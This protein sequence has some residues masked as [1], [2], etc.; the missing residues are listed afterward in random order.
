MPK[1]H[2]GEEHDR[3]GER[4][5][6]ADSKDLFSVEEG[7]GHLGWMMNRVYAASTKSS[8]M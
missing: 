1:M 6:N 7:D 8:N 4:S 2:D 5:K 3:D